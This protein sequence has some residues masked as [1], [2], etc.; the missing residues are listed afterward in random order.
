MKY[1]KV[2]WNHQHEAEPVLLYSE[3]NDDGF[4][5]RKIESYKSLPPGY[6]GPGIE[7]GKTW[8][9]INKIP[10]LEEIS[11]QPEFIPVEITADEFEREWRRVTVQELR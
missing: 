10:S 4:E 7:R 5:V 9:S 2:T 1:I 8:L 6:A 11:A 3:L